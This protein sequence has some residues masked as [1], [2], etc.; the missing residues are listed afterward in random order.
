MKSNADFCLQV[1]TLALTLLPAA[2]VYF[3]LKMNNK[4]K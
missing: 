1:A 2:V 4:Y 3:S